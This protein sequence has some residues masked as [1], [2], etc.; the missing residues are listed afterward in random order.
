MLVKHSSTQKPDYGYWLLP[1]GRVEISESLEDALRRE[2]NEELNLDIKIVRKL[3]EHTDPYTGDKLIN[4]LCRSSKSK[5]EI[6]SELAEARWF[7][8][9]EAGKL[10][11]INP[12]LKQ[13]L[14]NS[15]K[16]LF[17]ESDFSTSITH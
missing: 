7:N 4:F 12:E 9:N 1:A 3:I 16:S 15:L 13:F 5:I 17:L 2:I 11:N 14:V 8:L 10:R 6:S